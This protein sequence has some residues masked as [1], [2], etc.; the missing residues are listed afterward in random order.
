MK[1]KLHS[2]TYV[3]LETNIPTYKSKHAESS[4][5]MKQVIE[6]YFERKKNYSENEPVNTYWII[7]DVMVSLWV[8]HVRETTDI[9]VRVLFLERRVK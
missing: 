4:N 6:T 3:Y 2:Q 7:S 9:V 5:I 8:F 1:L